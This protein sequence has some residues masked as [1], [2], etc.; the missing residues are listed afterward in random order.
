MEIIKSIGFV[1]LSHLG[2][3]YSIASTLKGYDLICYDEDKN[4]A[5]YMY[6]NE[7]RLKNITYK[8]CVFC[9]IGIRYNI[10]FLFSNL[11]FWYIQVEPVTKLSEL[12]FFLNFSGF[13]YKIIY[14]F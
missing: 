8:T 6:P 14:F 2:L 11:F 9:N 12:N 4:K 13:F 10:S 1:G 3:N 5:T 7:A